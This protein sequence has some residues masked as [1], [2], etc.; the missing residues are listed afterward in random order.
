MQ[1]EGAS[2]D[3]SELPN[4]WVRAG[5][6]YGLL[7]DVPIPVS[8]GVL[9]SQTWEHLTK[10]LLESNLAN[11]FYNLFKDSIKQGKGMISKFLLAPLLPTALLSGQTTTC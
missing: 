1:I 2:A 4:R 9:H 8:S 10:A 6:L 11:V 5:L 3:D 7:P